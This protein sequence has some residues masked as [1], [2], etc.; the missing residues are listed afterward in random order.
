MKKQESTFSFNEIGYHIV[1]LELGFRDI[2]IYILTTMTDSTQKYG[3][4]MP[5]QQD[6]NTSH[7]KFKKSQQQ[8]CK[9][10]TV[11]KPFTCTFWILPSLFAKKLS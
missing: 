8:R 11:C 7:L 9:L 3:S 1:I 2:K 10:T 5:H 6:P 4:K